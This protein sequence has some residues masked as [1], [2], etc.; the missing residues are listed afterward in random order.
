METANVELDAASARD[1]IS[2]KPGPYVMVSMSDTGIGMDLETQGHLFE[3]F[4]TTKAQGKG[5]GLGLST[6]YGVVRQSGG[7]IAVDSAP[8]RGTTFS[9]FLPRVAEAAEPVETFPT[10]Q[11]AGKPLEG[12]ETIL[13]VEDEE[14]VRSLLCRSLQSKGYTVLEARLS[15][16]ALELVEQAERKVHLMLTDVVLPGMSGPELAEK[17]KA[18]HPGVKIIYMS[19]YADDTLDRHGM[20]EPGKHFIQKPFGAGDLVRKIREVLDAE[21]SQ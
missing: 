3:P 16:E 17:V 11:S 7:N 6:V 1:H 12:T 10:A 9:I 20:H 18:A 2:L 8:G 14:A 15:S 13:L 21:E 19:G 4:F 5:S